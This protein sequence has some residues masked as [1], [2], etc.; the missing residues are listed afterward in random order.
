MTHPIDDAQVLAVTNLRVH[1]FLYRLFAFN[2]VPRA[3][4]ADGAFLRHAFG[5]ILIN[6]CLITVR[7]ADSLRNIIHLMNNNN[8]VLGKFTSYL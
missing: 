1:Y 8:N 4:R 5:K 2:A 7:A 3:L 6:Y